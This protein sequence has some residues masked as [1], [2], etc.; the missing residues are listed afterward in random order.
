[1]ICCI[2]LAVCS[3][4]TF[5]VCHF[6]LGQT[7]PMIKEPYSG[8][9][10]VVNIT[11]TDEEVGVILRQNGH[12]IDSGSLRPNSGVDQGVSQN[13]SVN[14]SGR[15]LPWREEER[16]DWYDASF[17]TF[18]SL[19]AL[20]QG[21]D[22]GGAQTLHNIGQ[23]GWLFGGT[24][25][26][27]LGGVA[28]FASVILGGLLGG[29]DEFASKVIEKLDEILA[30]LD[31]IQ[32][33]IRYIQDRV[34]DIF[35]DV[36]HDFEDVRDLYRRSVAWNNNVWRASTDI[37]KKWLKDTAEHAALEFGHLV[38]ARSPWAKSKEYLQG[39]R[40]RHG[41]VAA[42][43]S[44]E[45]LSI[46]LSGL[47]SMQLYHF[48]SVRG[49]MGGK[50]TEIQKA[51]GEL[52]EAAEHVF[53]G[54]P[55]SFDMTTIPVDRGANED[56][57]LCL[58]ESFGGSGR[59]WDLAHFAVRGEPCT[60]KEDKR[61]L[62]NFY[63]EKESLEQAGQRR[64][65]YVLRHRENK[66]RISVNGKSFIVPSIMFVNA[67]TGNFLEAYRRPWWA[68]VKYP[69]VATPREDETYNTGL[70]SG[71]SASH[72]F[73]PFSISCGKQ[74]R[75]HAL[76]NLRATVESGFSL[77]QTG[78]ACK[79]PGSYNSCAKSWKWTEL[80]YVTNLPVSGGCSP[81]PWWYR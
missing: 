37:D 41:L 70:E 2:F 36:H 30:K 26:A 61:D 78:A 24:K 66:A 21:E 3:A 13:E 14:G 15:R 49:I 75:A 74:Y 10:I 9:V 58:R 47:L 73:I 19:I 45:D 39:V 33:S 23:L 68:S 67:K 62:T 44:L 20:A 22:A 11:V 1:M 53:G 77:L 80:H 65:W 63:G 28:G 59:P 8:G 64:W 76:V 40:D 60:G 43:Q 25:G 48:K 79:E 6:V 34:D 27:I 52:E 7:S 81:E 46:A 50:L 57:S 42:M 32:T 18:S 4:V 71:W 72:A 54:V 5:T 51:F 69:M 55:M 35:W 38:T 16:N 56:S 29:D 17:N 31:E 12:G